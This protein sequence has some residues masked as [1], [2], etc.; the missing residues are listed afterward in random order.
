MTRTQVLLSATILLCFLEVCGSAHRVSADGVTAGPEAKRLSLDDEFFAKGGLGIVNPEVYADLRSPRNEVVLRE[1]ARWA[2]RD[3]EA[4]QVLILWKNLPLAE[5]EMPA[6]FQLRSSIIISF[7]RT[8]VSFI[9]F[10]SG[11]SGFYARQAAP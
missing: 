1:G 9:D 10:Q 3:R 8:R 4:S 5:G 11:R 7:E 6:E 2:G